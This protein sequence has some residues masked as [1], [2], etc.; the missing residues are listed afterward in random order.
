MAA[1]RKIQQQMLELYFQISLNMKCHIPKT[2]YVLDTLN[3]N[4]SLLNKDLG[5]HSKWIIKKLW[6]VLFIFHTVYPN[7]QVEKFCTNM[8]TTHLYAA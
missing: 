3:L 7:L 1:F 2:I 8:S 6:Y 4:F 5:L